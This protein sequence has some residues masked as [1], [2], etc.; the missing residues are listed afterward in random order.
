MAYVKRINGYDVKDALVWDELG[1]NN[2][3]KGLSVAHGGTGATTPEKAR[4]NLGI[5]PAN[6]GASPVGHTHDADDLGSHEHDA[7]DIKGSLPIEHGGTGAT[8]AEQARLNLGITPAGIGASPV[9]HGHNVSDMI[10]GVLP[11]TRGGTEATTP[12]QAR[13]NLGVA[14]AGFGLGEAVADVQDGVADYIDK[15]GFYKVDISGVTGQSG[16]AYGY[17]LQMDDNTAF[18]RFE[19][20]LSNDNNITI[21][22]HKRNGVWESWEYENPPLEFGVEYRTTKK[23]RG[24]PI[25]CKW[26]ALGQSSAGTVSAPS[27]RTVEIGVDY[28]KV[29]YSSVMHYSNYTLSTEFLPCTANNAIAYIY[30]F[31]GTSIKIKSTGGT[32]GYQTYMYIEYI[33]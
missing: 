18:Q 19:Q 22:R 4:E 27:T 2:S 15:T 33:K 21:Q 1:I 23:Y 26:M 13:A 3:A 10:A 25:Y 16:F 30:W 24:Q 17:H 28:S 5:T 14:P 9:G 20:T 6:I 11:I 31:T 7:S 12:E 29:I 32:S 8:D